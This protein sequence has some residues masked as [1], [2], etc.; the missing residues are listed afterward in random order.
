MRKYPRRHI[1]LEN[2]VSLIFKKLSLIGL[3]I[4]GISIGIFISEYLRPVWI[5]VNTDTSNIQL[6][7]TPPEGCADLIS[8]EILNA[9]ESIYVQAF[10]LTDNQII[11]QLKNAANRGVYVH[12]LLDKTN[13]QEILN[14]LNQS[15]I[16]AQ[17]DHISGIAHNKVM[18]IDNHKVITGSFNFTK[19]ADTRNA[20]NVLLIDDELI[21][22][23]YINNFNSRL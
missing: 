15:S 2:I 1:K 19:S 13:T 18:I 16:K 22:K 9:K 23:E 10:A 4:L 5:P 12:I 3:V 11:Y 14:E 7:F 8:N 21:A 20:E 6:C 17:I